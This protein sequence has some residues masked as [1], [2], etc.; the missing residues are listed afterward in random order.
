MRKISSKPSASEGQ[1]KMASS[2][3]ADATAL[4]IPR[5]RQASA[6]W[7]VI[8]GGRAAIKVNAEGIVESQPLASRMEPRYSREEYETLFLTEEYLQFVEDENLRD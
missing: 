4:S 6:S 2:Q 3:T 5:S 8:M 1:I 7:H